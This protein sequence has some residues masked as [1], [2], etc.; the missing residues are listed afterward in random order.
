MYLKSDILKGVTSMPALT[1]EKKLSTANGIYKTQKSNIL[2]YIWKKRFLYLI[3]S[4]PLL[5]I[6]IFYYIPM[7]GTIISFLNYIPGQSIFESEWIGFKNFEM[8]FQS[9]LFI[10]A[11]RNTLI[12]SS[13]RLI[14][15]FPVPIITALLLN[16]VFNKYY[17]KGIQTVI[18]FPHFVSWVIIGGIILSFLSASD[19]LVNQILVSLGHEKISFLT[20]PKYFRLILVFSGIWK[21][22]GMSSVIYLAA[23]S[24]VDVSLYEAAII[25]GANRWQQTRYITL[26]EI[27]ETIVIIFILALS[28]IL[29]AGLDQVL[30]LLNPMVSDVGET[31]DT[32]VYKVGLTSGKFSL[33]TAMGL[34]K[35]AVGFFLIITSNAFIKRING[36][37]LF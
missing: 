14:F 10:G 35:S 37:S 28:G 13:Y 19:G 9:R 4:F 33:S 1:S 26:P 5:Y 3:L 21:E 2:K 34:F 15:S 18:V 12:I 32:Y 23:V 7:Y 17:K 22:F 11:L 36:K 31:L 20:E 27:K 24:S 29:N 8:I 6:L 16:E 25:D 30:V